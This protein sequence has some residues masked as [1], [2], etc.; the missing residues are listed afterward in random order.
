MPCL[1]GR[2]RDRCPSCGGRGEFHGP[3]P[4]EP[5]S[6]EFRA[7]LRRLAELVAGLFRPAD[8][9]PVVVPAEDWGELWR[10]EGGE[11]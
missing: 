7:L 8:Q 3:C 10:D 6:S 2:L 11:G 1:C 5:A 9:G 4:A